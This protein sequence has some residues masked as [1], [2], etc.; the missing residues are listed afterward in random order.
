MEKPC[1]WYQGQQSKCLREEGENCIH[2]TSW[3][4]CEYGKG[5]K[6]EE[7]KRLS[8]DQAKLAKAKDITKKVFARLDSEG[9]KHFGYVYLGNSSLLTE[10]IVNLIK[11]LL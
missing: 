9:V 4:S 3:N 6:W 11:N 5:G 7:K 2:G 1:F 10:K 8:T